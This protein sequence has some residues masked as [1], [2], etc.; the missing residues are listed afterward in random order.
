MALTPNNR[1][2]FSMRTHQIKRKAPLVLVLWDSTRGQKLVFKVTTF[3]CLQKQAACQCPGRHTESVRDG[4]K[5]TQSRKAMGPDNPEAYT[6]S[7]KDQRLV[8]SMNSLSL[9]TNVNSPLPQTQSLVARSRVNLSPPDK[10]KTM[11]CLLHHTR[12]LPLSLTSDHQNAT[13]HEGR[14]PATSFFVC[15]RTLSSDVTQRQM[16]I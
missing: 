13:R 16:N 12:S 10:Q 7:G 1:D 5:S 4:R 9:L 3:Q 14:S 8:R 2:Y 11:G 6:P 15:A